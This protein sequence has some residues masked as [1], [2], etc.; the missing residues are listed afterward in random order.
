MKKILVMVSV[1]LCPF[2]ASSSMIAFLDE[3][4]NTQQTWQA[5]SKTVKQRC[6]SLGTQ[7]S[8]TA[9]ENR[10]YTGSL[11]NNLAD[12]LDYFTVHA[13]EYRNTVVYQSRE[14]GS[15]TPVNLSTPLRRKR[16]DGSTHYLNHGNYVSNAAYDFDRTLLHMPFQIFGLDR[17]DPTN[18]YKY[19]TFYSA[20]EFPSERERPGKHIVDALDELAFGGGANDDDLGA[21]SI[22]VVLAGDAAEDLCINKD[23]NDQV[24]RLYQRGIAVVVGL[25]NE[26]IPTTELTWPACLDHVIK[27]GSESAH[28]S[29]NLNGIGIGAMGLDFFAKDTTTGGEQGNSFAAPRIAAAYALLHREYNFSSVDQKTQALI[30]ANKRTSFYN[31]RNSN[32]SLFKK[33]TLRYVKK[34][35]MPAAISILGNSFPNGVSNEVL[36]AAGSLN[37]E[38]TNSYGPRY[39]G[40][41]SS[42]SF[43]IDLDD[44]LPI[45][46]S[47]S[48]LAT[49]SSTSNINELVLSNKRDI[50]LKFTSSYSLSG[51][52][53]FRIKINGTTRYTTSNNYAAGGE[54]EHTLIISGK[55]LSEGNNTITLEPSSVSSDWGV[56][57]ISATFT[58]VVDITV[59]QIDTNQ[60]GYNEDPQRLTGMRAA[61]DLQ[62]VT[63]DLVLSVTGW[64]IDTSNETSVFINGTPIGFLSQSPSNDAYSA[65]DKF[66]LLKSLLRIGLNY[67]E[68]VQRETDSSWV[69]EDDE[70]WAVK[71]ILVAAYSE[72]GITLQL[73]T[74]D[75]G[76]YGRGYG[77]S[78]N[79]FQLDAAFTAQTEHDHKIS[80]QGFDVDQSTDVAV[81]LNG[82]FIKNVSTTGNNA[83]GQTET[84]TIAWRKF[85]SGS[86]TMSFRVNTSGFD[87]T[88]GVTNLLVETSD[89][90]DLDDR[91][92]LNVEYGYYEQQVDVPAGWTRDY[93]GEGHQTRLYATFDSNATKDKTIEVTGWDIDSDQEMAIYLNGSFIRYVSS[94]N[95]S[96]IYSQTDLITLP[97]EDLVNG[98]NT[99]LFKTQD[100]FFGFQNEKWGLIFGNKTAK[101]IN[102]VPI[103]MLLLDG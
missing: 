53:G 77:T 67:I 12:A 98:T 69:G 87:T 27:V 100:S 10:V 33:H 41:G 26:D 71:D 5:S 78:T 92:N 9:T 13:A 4:I 103:V 44:L 84:I 59:G 97:K 8:V 83:V 39:L 36:I 49:L 86:N 82:T 68:F 14:L 43:N 93:S 74:T 45:L 63:D 75:T 21:V 61:F 88:W 80:W 28:Q 19:T 22:S 95:L 30:Q 99:L 17:Q 72:D 91:S 37:Y 34:T 96:S 70:K 20:I 52:R 85:Q 76:M 58:P 42:H 40:S 47:D 73:G 46:T 101:T 56:K 65:E 50:T 32:G 15:S 29:I 79:F 54:V 23:G 6:R 55:Y 1:M 24:Y 81:Y 38:D 31:Q 62:A 25:R 51:T 94:P 18:Q 102:L 7:F 64:D 89:V 3:G 48:K 57:N 90:I 11:C 2:G 66:L 35:D 60:Y 16:A